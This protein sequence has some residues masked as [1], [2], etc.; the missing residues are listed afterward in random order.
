[1]AIESFCCIF[2]IAAWIHLVTYSQSR[3]LHLFG[4]DVWILL[5]L[6][7]VV[8]GIILVAS[9]S[10]SQRPAMPLVILRAAIWLLI[11]L[12]LLLTIFRVMELHKAAYQTK[13]IITA[14]WIVSITS[15]SIWFILILSLLAIYFRIQ[16]LRRL[17][18]PG[19]KTNSQQQEQWNTKADKPNRIISISIESENRGS[20]EKQ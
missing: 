12:V 18:S 16:E 7:S 11:T 14:K 17:K 19:G 13:G 1:M 8:F 4:S 9:S 2:L 10:R 15:F 6:A 5:P 20:P 3:G